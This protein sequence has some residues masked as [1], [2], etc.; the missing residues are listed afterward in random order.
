LTIRIIL[1]VFLSFAGLA[2]PFL[3]ILLATRG[4]SEWRIAAIYGAWALLAVLVSF[5]FEKKSIFLVFLAVSGLA[6]TYSALIDYLH[7]TIF[8]S[9]IT[10]STIY[11]TME[12]NQNET[13]EFFEM[14]L[15]NE[16]VGIAFLFFL[17][18]LITVLL[19]Y[20]NFR[21]IEKFRNSLPKKSFSLSVGIV[22]C[23]AFLTMGRQY[24]LPY[25]M[26]KSVSEF[27]A[28]REELASTKIEKKGYFQEV[29][30]LFDEEQQTCVL[31]I[32]ESTTST[33]M[34]LYGYYR[35]TN[36]LLTK[37]QDELMIYENV[38]SPHTHTISSLSKALTVGNYSE[39][40]EIFNHTLIQLFNHAGFKTYFISNQNPIGQYE[41]TVTL[42]A[43]ASDEIVHTNASR[44][45]HDEVLIEPLNRALADKAKKKLI[46][47][48]MMGTHSFYANRYPEEYDL[49][50]DKPNTKFE[51]EEAYKTINE[52]DNAMVYNDYIVDAI[53]TSVEEMTENAYVLYFSD[54]GEDVFETIDEAGHTE[55]KGTE[56]MYK[57]P[58]VLWQSTDF[59]SRD[60][61]LTWDTTRRFNLR[62][63]PH[64]VADLSGIRF[65]GFLPEKSLVNERFNEE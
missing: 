42:L 38:K 20:R 12:T 57:I 48:H 58:F 22:L 41:T 16:Q 21:L 62:D 8:R 18:L 6:Y 55:E 2:V 10:A 40:G 44:S 47:L 46:I 59:K 31:V 19:S 5:L 33:H 30:Y 53:I 51:H 35:P 56:P 13:R 29:D 11:I 54:H 24:F 32:G 15:R 1:K 37:R 50:R 52:Y 36:P 17:S 26:A 39:P 3:F 61:T 60:S 63:L 43:K 23:V 64:T 49:F 65:N 9:R 14:Y 7:Y 27:I 4:T 34:E 45:L 25:V 28:G